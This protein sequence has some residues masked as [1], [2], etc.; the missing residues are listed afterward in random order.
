MFLFQKVYVYG[1]SISMQY[2]YPLEKQLV[3][4]NVSYNRKGN[5]NSIDLASSIYNGFSTVEMLNWLDNEPLKMD[6]VIV[7]NCGLHDI[8]HI[9]KDDK[10]QVSEEDYKNNLK[11]IVDKCKKKFGGVMFCNTTPVDDERHNSGNE[12]RFRYNNDVIRY[13]DIAS[14]VMIDKGIF[15]IDLYTLTNME[16]K[17]SQIYIDHIHVC[18]KVSELHAKKIISSLIDVGYIYEL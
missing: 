2:G 7:F 6:T 9:H 1:D 15:I 11:K 13:N 4:M 17:S 16:R 3:D 18:K 5:G 14:D 12:C 8:L 10:C